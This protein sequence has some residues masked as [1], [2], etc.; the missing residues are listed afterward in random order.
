MHDTPTATAQPNVITQNATLSAWAKAGNV[1]CQTRA[2]DND[3]ITDREQHHWHKHILE[4]H[5]L[6]A[7]R[8]RDQE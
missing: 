1:A 8:M 5:F 6:Q 3:H 2:W 7:F 4:V